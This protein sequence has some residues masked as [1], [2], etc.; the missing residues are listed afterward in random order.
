MFRRGRSKSRPSSTLWTLDNSVAT[1]CRRA[2]LSRRSCGSTPRTILWALATN[3]SSCSLERTL[4]WRNRS[5]NSVRLF[6]TLSRN[7]A[8]LGIMWSLT[9]EAQFSGGARDRVMRII[10]APQGTA[11]LAWL[12]FG[13]AVGHVVAPGVPGPASWIPGLRP[14]IDV[15]SECSHAPATSRLSVDP[16]LTAAD[17]WQ[18]CGGW[19]VAIHDPTAGQD[20]G[21]RRG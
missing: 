6:T 21:P 1:C 16:R 17:A 19:C 5:K 13:A 14:G 8:Q 3:W 2:W 10:I 9:W 4:S 12:G 18:S 15:S 7:Y 20:S 11:L